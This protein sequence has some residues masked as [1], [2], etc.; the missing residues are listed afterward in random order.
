MDSDLVWKNPRPDDPV[1]VW[2]YR[3]HPN[4]PGSEQGRR[5]H[6]AAEAIE[7]YGRATRGVKFDAAA[8]VTRPGEYLELLAEMRD[9]ITAEIVETVATDYERGV[10]SLHEMGR[11]LRQSPSSLS[12][13]IKR[14][15]EGQWGDVH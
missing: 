13:W 15:A 7:E 6:Y 10:L 3:Y 12:R 14:I 8:Q 2:R 1:A 11:A 9:L 4:S 5:P